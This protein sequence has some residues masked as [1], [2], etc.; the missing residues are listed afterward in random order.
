MKVGG[1]SVFMKQNVS[2]KSEE[3]NV[4]NH[5]VSED[6]LATRIR[7]KKKMGWRTW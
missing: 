3:M 6:I 2:L 1:V 7:Y 5:E 4:T